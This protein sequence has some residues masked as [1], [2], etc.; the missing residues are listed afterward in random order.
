MFL[1]CVHN[2]RL[3]QI[4]ETIPYLIKSNKLKG[5][6]IR[7][8]EYIQ[9]YFFESEIYCSYSQY[10]GLYCLVIQFQSSTIGFSGCL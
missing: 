2:K 6:K 9:H 3:T 4:S 7:F 10:V 1:L 5:M 8:L